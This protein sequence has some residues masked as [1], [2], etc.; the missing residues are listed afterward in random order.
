MY[1]DHFGL[2]ETPFSIAP[3]PRYLY[4]SEF[5]REALAHLLYGI[6][7]DGGFVLLTGE[8]GTG[9]TTVCRCL[10][11]QLPDTIDAA[12][13]LNPKLTSQELLATLCDE[14]GISYPERAIGIKIFVD[15]INAHLL[16]SYAKGRKS[17]LIIDEA[18]N[19]SSDVL[20]QIRLL[21]NLETNEHKL[22]QIIM[23][24]QPE[25]REKLEHPE[26]KQL[27]QRITARYHLGPLSRN[28]IPAYIAHRLQV[29]GA[30]RTLFSSS[31]I[32]ALYRFSGGIPRLINIVC[33]RAL[34]GAFVKGQEHVDSAVLSSAAREVFGR[35]EKHAW[36]KKM[37]QWSVIA[38]LLLGT[39][40]A[41]VGVSTMR[42][43]I[44]IT[45]GPVVPNHLD[46]AWWFS[47][48]PPFRQQPWLMNEEQHAG[49]SGNHKI[50]SYGNSSATKK[51]RHKQ[52]RKTQVQ[53]NHTTMH[54]NIV[55]S[56]ENQFKPANHDNEADGDKRSKADNQPKPDNQSNPTDNQ[57]LNNQLN[58]ENQQK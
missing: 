34:L 47:D 29:A 37:L 15:M 31:T 50:E 20:E 38:F 2:T 21:T 46:N 7:S 13:I 10:L 1:K 30:Q 53:K 24:G 33:D 54:E 55:H 39:I 18:Q 16:D 45:P 27:A 6:E 28:D 43:K 25:L 56:T 52:R 26:L 23:L 22:L 51:K 42:P 49:F 58:P 17:I 48:N 3:N 57:S 9:K 44:H 36:Q 4:M 11:E 19:L 40:F 35:D 12:L 14:F 32:K 8:V 5:H 41:F